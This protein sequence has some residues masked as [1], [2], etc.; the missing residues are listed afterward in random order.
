MQEIIFIIEHLTQTLQIFPSS[1]IYIDI[2]PDRRV[3]VLQRR[4][5]ELCLFHG[6][7]HGHLQHGYPEL[8]LHICLV[9][10][11]RQRRYTEIVHIMYPLDVLR[12]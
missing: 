5:N 3:K 8:L 9:H 2:L 4:L 6:N 10:A 1:G 11:D 12:L 7:L